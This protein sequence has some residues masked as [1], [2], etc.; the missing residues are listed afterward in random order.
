MFMAAN[1]IVWDLDT[2]LL[3]QCKQVGTRWKLAYGRVHSCLRL[4]AA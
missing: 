3:W 2:T 4:G 1:V